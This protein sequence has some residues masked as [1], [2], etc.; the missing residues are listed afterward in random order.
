M[1]IDLKFEINV[2][3]PKGQRKDHDLGLMV[4]RNQQ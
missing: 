3:W 4:L 2:K 1:V